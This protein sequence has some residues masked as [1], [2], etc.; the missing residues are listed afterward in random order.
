LLGATPTAIATFALS[1][2][3][4]AGQEQVAQSI[5]L[6]TLASM[7]TLPLVSIWVLTL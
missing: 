2:D 1:V 4:D 3:F 6:T 7:V 5:V